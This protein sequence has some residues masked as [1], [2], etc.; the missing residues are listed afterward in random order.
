MTT[1]ARI[2]ITL[3]LAILFS[4]CGFDINLGNGKK[5]NGIVEEEHR[6]VTSDFTSVKASEGVGVY[7]TQGSELEILVEADENVI[8]LIATDIKDGI[9]RIHTIEN[10]G[11]ATKKVYVS[12][13]IITALETSSGAHM[14]TNTNIRTENLDLS[15]TSG[16]KIQIKELMAN[17]LNIDT[18]SGANIIVAGTAQN[19]DT[20]ASS[21]SDIKAENLNA[22]IC[23][24]NASSGADITINVSQSLIAEASSG[25]D[26]RYKGNAKVEQKKSSSGKVKQL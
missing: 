5:G 10:I 22:V 23:R 17:Q 16:S 9:L 24:A 15:A 4:S 1:L 11:R 3:I 2:T 6:K 8:D 21:G 18:S 13:P 20:S 7:I 26:I 12:L 25:G 19:V 14:T